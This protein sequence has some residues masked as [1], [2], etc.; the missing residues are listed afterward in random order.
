MMIK[1][2]TDENN[3]TIIL[4]C[5]CLYVLKDF[6]DQEGR[7]RFRIA[8]DRLLLPGWWVYPSQA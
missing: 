6:D 4:V 5:V 1:M 2:N 7:N 8:G 3:V